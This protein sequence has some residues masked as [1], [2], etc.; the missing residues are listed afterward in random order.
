MRDNK[1]LVVALTRSEMFQDYAQAYTE[2]TGMPLTLRPVNTWQLPF[3]GLRKENLFCALIAAKSR[4]CAACLQLQEKLTQAAQGEPATRTCAYGL[5]ETAVPVKLGDETI[6]F[7]QTGQRLRQ[8]PTEGAFQLAIAQAARRGVDIDDEPTRLAY[9]ATPVI[10]AKRLNAATSLLAIFADHLAMK[11]NQL[12]VQTANVE[13]P[14]IAQARQFIDEHYA[15]SLSLG[16]VSQNVNTSRFYF[17]KLFRKAT[18]LSFTEF[19]SRTRIEKAKTMLLN[20]NLRVSEIA[21]AAGFQSLSHF[22]RMFKRIVGRSP[23]DYRGAL[24][25]AA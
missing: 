9:F 20:R 14:I 2:A 1:Q 22:A 11:G 10:S 7:L 21:F 5:C 18:G 3:R 4:T 15:E 8:I 6:G 16:R 19:V 13:S 17:C 12:A 24:L 23:S 25:V